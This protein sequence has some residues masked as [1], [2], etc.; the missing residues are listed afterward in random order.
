VRTYY[1]NRIFMGFCCVCCEV[2]Y[3]ALYLLSWPK[4]AS[5]GVLRLPPG[6]LAALPPGLAAAL[7]PLG[8]LQRLGGVPAA[9]VIALL[10]LPGVAIKQTCN[11]LQLR[12][13]AAGLV[14]YDVKRME[15]ATTPPRVTRS[16]AK[17]A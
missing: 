13:A 1:S 3:L 9:A 16:A 8:A 12:N 14:E 15:A 11:W 5:F 2:Q 6:L 17:R 7:P 4:F 10:V